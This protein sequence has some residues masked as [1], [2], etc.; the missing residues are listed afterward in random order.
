MDSPQFILWGGTKPLP[1]EWYS[2]KRTTTNPVRGIK[3]RYHQLCCCPPLRRTARGWDSWESHFPKS[4]GFSSDCP[5]HDR[6]GR[7]A[8]CLLF[9]GGRG[10]SLGWQEAFP[11]EF[12]VFCGWLLPLPGMA[13]GLFPCFA[14]IGGLM[15]SFGVQKFAHPL[16]MY[17]ANPTK[18]FWIERKT[19]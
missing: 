7:V 18:V 9:V 17:H 14:S 13:I 6:W 15:F 12:V 10:L 19:S 8:V 16:F 3:S 4:F 11:L 1:C 2:L 5:F